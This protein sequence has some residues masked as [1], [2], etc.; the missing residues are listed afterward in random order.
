M[1]EAVA[2]VVAEVRSKSDAA[3]GP[4]R[5]RK[6]I[7]TQCTCVRKWNSVGGKSRSLRLLHV[8]AAHPG[9]APSASATQHDDG[10]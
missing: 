1:V 9:A 4:K 3:S 5:R 10:F 8:C 6:C 2:A 7:N